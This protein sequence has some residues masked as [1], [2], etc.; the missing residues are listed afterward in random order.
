MYNVCD[1]LDRQYMKAVYQQKSTT[2]FASNISGR[3]HAKMQHVCGTREDG[4]PD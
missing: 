3:I 4:P 1:T 2:F